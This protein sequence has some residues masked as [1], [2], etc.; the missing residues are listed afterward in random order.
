MTGGTVPLLAVEG[1]TKQFGSLVAN[2]DVSFTVRAG[3][4]HCLLG[5][6]GAG[7][8][9]LVKALYGIHRPDGGRF[10]VDGAEVDIASPAVARDLGVGMVFQDLRLVPALT[11]WENVALQLPDT[12]RVLHRR[13][14]QDRIAAASLEYGLEVDPTARVRDLSIGEWQRVELLKVLLAGAR[15]LILD[16]P[17]SVLTPQE[18]G[19]LFS[20]VRRLA[21][22][23]VGVVLIAHKIGEV[24][25]IADR[26]TVL[27]G[28]RTVLA[29]AD[30]AS[31]SD[32]ELVQ[33]MVGRS[34]TAVSRRDRG[35]D[36]VTGA[37]SDEPAVG[38]G[39]AAVPPDAPSVLSVRAVDIERPDGS[40]ALAG[41]DLEV[42]AGEIL[43]VA[44]V[45][46]NGQAELVDLLV[47]AVTASAGEVRVGGEPLTSPLAFRRAGVVD[48]VPHPSRQFVV[49]TLTIGQHAALWDSAT[50]TGKRFDVRAAM[51]RFAGR[52]AEA[53]LRTAEPR[54]RL[55]RLS[56][57]NVQR[58][59]L[60]LALTG[61][62][63][64]V[65]A[66]YPTR[67]LDVLTAAR[68]H[69]LI[70]DARAR[71]AAVVLVSE[72]LDELLALSDR[73]AVL[74]GGHVAGMVSAASATREQLG[75]LMT[76][77][78]GEGVAA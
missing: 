34:V 18:V 63:R 42:A 67:G 4:V 9:T 11:V 70:L 50:T 32:D 40:R 23:G 12:A 45:A 6:N 15:L 3:E 76:S 21:A 47:G 64:L 65:V 10:V 26:V 55:D 74:S 36:P 30:P 71:G 62:A 22:R 66:S 68:T 52:D 39:T 19:A 54:R 77:D 78:L 61:D 16:E 57:G 53:G 51:R 25:Q 60:T 59:M 24:R 28:G 73:V 14:I 43:G 7:K 29:D 17:T 20:V 2:D 46:G 1:L 75:A 27:R 69:E 37:P 33:A 48:V 8:S 41:V 49:R 5:E 13:A 58:V 35:V 56:G 44:G 31:L 72:D 38:A